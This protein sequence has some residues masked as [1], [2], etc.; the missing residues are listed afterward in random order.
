MMMELAAIQYSSTRENVLF[1]TALGA[2]AE[3]GILACRI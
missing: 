1:R 2:F 3:Q